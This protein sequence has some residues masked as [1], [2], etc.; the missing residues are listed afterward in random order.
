VVFADPAAGE[1]CPFNVLITYVARQDVRATLPNGLQVITGPATATATNEETGKTAVYNISGPGKLDPA[2]KRLT[3]FG[4][5]LILQST[6]VGDFIINRPIDRP[7]RGH[8]SH[9]I[10]AELT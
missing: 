9:D 4:Q 7:L 6:A 1:V 3:L 2:T 5:S 8:V 10:C